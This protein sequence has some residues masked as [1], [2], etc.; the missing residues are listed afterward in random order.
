V[1]NLLTD[2]QQNY[3]DA[4][5]QGSSRQADKI[6][7]K[8]LDARVSAN[9]IYLDIFQNTAY[10]IGRMWQRNQFSVAQ[11]HLAT[12]IIERQMGELH[13]YFKPVRERSRRLVLGAVKDEHHRV[14]LRMVADFFEQDGWEVYYLGAAVPTNTFVSI[15]RDFHADLIGVSAQMVYHL[16][17]VLTFVKEID[18]QGLN[19]IPIM[20]G[21]F[22]FVQ[23][24]DLFK[25]MGVQ[26]T[27]VDANEALRLANAAV[28]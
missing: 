17:E 19:G 27:G 21:G 6:V 10:E 18:R 5:R 1:E 8:A 15:V 22:P 28:Q 14:G 7:A 16:P 11:E 25:S 2:L 24:P 23:N 3:L 26:F 20:A 9:G 12:A 4:M 13:P